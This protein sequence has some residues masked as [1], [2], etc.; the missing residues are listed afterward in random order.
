MKWF[1]LIL[2]V[3]WLHVWL[4]ILLIFIQYMKFWQTNSLCFSISIVGFFRIGFRQFYFIRYRA[5]SLFRRKL[6]NT[7]QDWS[8]SHFRMMDFFVLDSWAFFPFDVQRQKRLL[9]LEMLQFFCCLSSKRKSAVSEI[10]WET[11]FV[12][13]LNS[14][15][16]F[17]HHLF[18]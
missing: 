6:Q 14:C 12:S 18:N 15:E 5:L 10:F 17:S 13:S 16:G 4:K 7:T 9:Q 8:C 1:A 11:P 2:P 3:N